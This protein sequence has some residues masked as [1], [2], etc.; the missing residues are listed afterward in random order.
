MENIRQYNEEQFQMLQIAIADMTSGICVF[1]SYDPVVQ[2]KIAQELENKSGKSCLILDMSQIPTDSLPDDIGKLRRLL[3]GKEDVTV[4]I[5]CNLQVCGAELGDVEYAQKLNYMRDQMMSMGKVWVL[6]M[7]PYFAVVLSREARDLYS[8]IM[9]HFK[10]QEKEEEQMTG[11]E[12]TEFYGDLKLDMSHLEELSGRIANR[13]I[14]KMSKAE[15]LQAVNAWNHV[16]EYG[17]EKLLSKIQEILRYLEEDMDRKRFT[18]KDCLDYQCVVLAWINLEK[19]DEA[20]RV[21]QNIKTRAEQILPEQCKEKA[22]I[23]LMLAKVYFC[24]KD[25]E[26]AEKNVDLALQYD[27]DE[28]SQRYSPRKILA[29]DLLAILKMEKGEQEKSLEIYKELIEGVIG[30]YG[31]NYAMMSALWNNYGCVYMQMRKYPEALHCFQNAAAVNNDRIS[32][33]GNHF[34]NIGQI[35][36][37]MGDYRQAISYLKK[38]E[39]IFLQ[40]DEPLRDQKRLKVVHELLTEYEKKAN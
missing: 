14:E 18:A 29:M 25:N 39:G 1:Q 6:G 22:G 37:K 35:Y 7:S 16:Y 24:L 8:C 31:E 3:Q 38:A 10:F 27:S 21:M 20:L 36:G 23:Y 13:G 28:K 4:V 26:K 12:E 15:L 17:N 30:Q 11:F 40:A 33:R 2:K 19:Y 5:L 34:K 32:D 9:N